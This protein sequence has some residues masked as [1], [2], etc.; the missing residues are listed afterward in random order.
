MH[1]KV[2][3][4]GIRSWTLPLFQSSLVPHS[5]KKVTSDPDSES[6]IPMEFVIA[7]RNLTTN[8]F[9]KGIR[10]NPTNSS[11]ITKYEKLLIQPKRKKRL[12]TSESRYLDLLWIIWIPLQEVDL[13]A[14]EGQASSHSLI[15]VVGL[16]H[17]L[18]HSLIVI[19]AL[20]ILKKRIVGLNPIPNLFRSSDHDQIKGRIRDTVLLI[21][22]YSFSLSEKWRGIGRE[23]KKGLPSQMMRCTNFHHSNA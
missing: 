2:G 12:A 16:F 22:N 10:G 19:S 3:S 9:Y 18:S 13:I 1:Y 14:K 6:A 11:K 5:L 17:N 23:S 21:S 20:T 8:S 7:S 15:R 4:L